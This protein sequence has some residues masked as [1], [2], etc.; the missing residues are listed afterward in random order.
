MLFELLNED[1]IS[2]VYCLTRRESPLEA[3]VNSLANKD[4]FL[5]PEQ[6]AKVVALNSRLDQPNFGLTLDDA[7]IQHMLD[8][9]SLII[10]SAWP[11]NFNLPFS[12][13]ES[14]IQGLYNLIQFSLSVHRREPAIMM[15]CSSIS[16]ALS[17]LS[18]EVPE[19]PVDL[20][21][22]FG[23][24]GQSKVA[25]EHIVSHARQIGAR[26]YSLRIGQV[27]GHSKKGLWNG[28][29]ALPLMIRSALALG[30]LPEISQTCSWLPVDKL[31][32]TVIE[33]AKSCAASC[34]HKDIAT[35]S[36]SAA[37]YVDD[38]IFNL[39]NPREFPWSS[40]LT[41]LKHVGF[42]FD[43]LP[44]QDWLERLRESEAKGEE[45]VNPAV[46]LIQH[47]EAMYGSESS[48]VYNGPRR[49]LTEKAESKSVTFRNGRLR[50]I[51]DGIMRCYAEDWLRRWTGA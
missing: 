2:T 50:I 51:E 7:M 29:E 46:K 49:F 18:L 45:V 22:A 44:F 25:G 42:Q 27:S 16:A 13:F 8:S 9:V 34:E 12:E 37:R 19:E 40:L 14:H 17:S 4:L 24:Y 1:S 20:N 5:S 38:S 41:T 48:P 21:C 26:A 6:L 33:L 28:S 3:V 10:H 43:I 11:V 35:A 30:A 15:F 36:S 23:G 39:C 47:Y 31:A 32:S